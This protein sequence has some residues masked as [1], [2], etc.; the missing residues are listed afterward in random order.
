MSRMRRIRR[1]LTLAEALIALVICAALL[2][3]MAVA[4]SAAG[5]AFEMNDHFYRSLQQARSGM[6]LMMTEIR[7]ANLTGSNA[8]TVTATTVTLPSCPDFGA[9]SITFT[10]NTTGANAD[11][12]TLTDNNTGITS[13]LVGENPNDTLPVDVSSASF[14]GPSGGVITNSTGTAP[15]GS[16]S[17]TMTVQLGRYPTMNEVILS[18]SSAPRASCSMAFQ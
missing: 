17:L 5:S 16:I 18:G 14:T 7:R 4:F 10:Y 11:C 13:I 9:H 8:I 12:I 15:N 3:C 2:A 6:D 1:G